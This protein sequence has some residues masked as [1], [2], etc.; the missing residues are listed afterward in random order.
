MPEEIRIPKQKRSIEKK[1]ALKK[2]AVELFSTKG[3]HNT[4]SNEIAKKANVSIGT[5]YSYFVDKK[6]LYEELITDLYNESLQEITIMDVSGFTSP[7]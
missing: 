2:A 1:E 3:F 5:F 6:S 7:R 4:S